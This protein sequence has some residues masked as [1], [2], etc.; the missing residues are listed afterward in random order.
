MN[1]QP[2]LGAGCLQARAADRL[3]ARWSSTSSRSSAGA[4]SGRHRRR[5][6]APRRARASARDTGSPLVNARYFDVVC[7][8][9]VSTLVAVNPGSTRCRFHSDRSINIE[10]MPSTTAS[11]ICTATSDPSARRRPGVSVVRDWRSSGCTFGRAASAAGSNATIIE[12]AIGRGE[13]RR[14]APSSRARSGRR[15]APPAGCATTSAGSATRA[16]AMPATAPQTASTAC[17]AISCLIKRPRDAPSAVRSAISP[18]RSIERPSTSVPRLTA[19]SIRIRSDRAKQDQQGR[20]NVAGDRVLQRLHAH[21]LAP[22][23]R[24]VPRSLRIAGARSASSRVAASGVTPG[25]SR[26]TPCENVALNCALPGTQG[27]G[28]HR[29]VPGRRLQSRPA[30]RRRSCA[31]PDRVECRGR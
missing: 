31:V 10:P 1:R 23:V 24:R 11:A 7:S 8:R 6:A 29:S 17:S 15:A 3:G 18:T 12:T 9:K 27:S 30:S 28:A 21:R 16:T 26:A 19:A 20:T 4:R 13:H 2:T 22:V 5:P 25:A 14:P